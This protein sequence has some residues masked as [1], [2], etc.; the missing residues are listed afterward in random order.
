MGTTRFVNA[1]G[2]SIPH[3]TSKNTVLLDLDV[4]DSFEVTLA[5][6]TVGFAFHNVQP[7]VQSDVYV[8]LIQDSTGGRLTAWP[9]TV[10][11]AG[12]TPT[13]GLVHLITLDGVNWYESADEDVD[14]LEN[15]TVNGNLATAGRSI[16]QPSVVSGTGFTPNAAAD[17][18]VVANITPAAGAGTVAVALSSNGGTSYTTLATVTVLGSGTVANPAPVVVPNVPAGWLVKLTATTAS[19][20]TVTVY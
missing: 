19:L 8:L 18:N 6:G 10:T 2:T 3:Y 16:T 4:T 5:T 1:N 13:S 7:G 11:F 20:G 15:L 12:V 14:S 9:S 17:A